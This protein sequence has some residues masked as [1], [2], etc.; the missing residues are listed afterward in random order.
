MR[1]E[2][3]LKEPKS[4][5][6]P[7]KFPT[8]ERSKITVGAILEAATYILEHEDWENFST[9]RVAEKAGVN[10]ASLYQYFPNKESILSEIFRMHSDEIRAT[11]REL[12]TVDLSA[13]NLHQLLEKIVKDYVRSHQN[14][15]RLHRILQA[16]VPK[17]VWWIDENNAGDLEVVFDKLLRNRTE[18]L[19]NKKFAGF[20]LK[21][22][23]NAMIREAVDRHPDY[24]S[25]P[26]FVPEMVSFFEAYL[27]GSGR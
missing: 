13:L 16:K 2:T 17:S 20:F 11:S 22:G 27:S 5:A 26:D 21:T 1:S 4:A 18:K 14:E 24:L 15:P 3:H 10:I 25:D 9:N 19:K 23:L 7:K 6:K 12:E 8:Q